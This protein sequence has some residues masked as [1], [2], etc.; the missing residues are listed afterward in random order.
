MFKRR[1]AEVWGLDVPPEPKKHASLKSH[2]VPLDTWENLL[3]V[4]RD[5]TKEFYKDCEE[6]PRLL[7]ILLE[8]DQLVGLE[9]IKSSLVQTI[10][11]YTQRHT[12]GTSQLRHVALMGPPG[13]G[14]TTLCHLL[15]RLYCAMGM[16]KT[17]KVVFVTP[18]Q[19]IGNVMGATVIKTQKKIDECQEAVMVIDEV[20]SLRSAHRPT[21]YAEQC[22]NTLNRN[23]DAQDRNWILM[24]AGYEKEV[25]ECFFKGNPGLWSRFPTKL[26]IKPYTTAQLARMCHHMIPKTHLKLLDPRLLTKE[27]FAQHKDM[28]PSYGRSILNFLTKVRKVH[29]QR[30]HGKPDHL[31]Q[32][33][34]LQDVERGFQRYK[35]EDV[36]EKHQDEQAPPAHM[37]I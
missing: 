5:S 3:Q 2:P 35:L 26:R 32:I 30:V 6:L 1:L 34:T 12:F 18:D 13:T 25:K 11:D 17:D 24:V 22:I 29:A 15:A 33:I 20:Y 27:W 16:I 28:F 9:D 10:L 37:Y 19:L 14:K 31:K 23:L 8:I 4:A 7:P 36:C 21:V